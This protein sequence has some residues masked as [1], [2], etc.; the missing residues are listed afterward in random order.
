[1]KILYVSAMCGPRKIQDIHVRYR[2]NPGFAMQ[3]FNRLVAEGLVAAGAAVST[4]SAVPLQKGE[5]PTWCQFPSETCRGVRYRYIPFLNVEGIKQLMVLLYTFFY[6]LLW[7]M[8]GGK[9]KRVVCDVLNVS[10]CLGALLASK[11]NG[12]TTCGIITDLPGAGNYR[13]W[14]NMIGAKVNDL[15]VNS[16]DCYVLLTEAMNDKVNT[17]KR[18]YIVMEGL[19]DAT[20]KSADTL[21][22]Q[23]RTRS[24]V[25]AG[26]LYEKYGVKTLLDAFI[27]TGNQSFTLDLYGRGPMEDYIREQEAR[28]PRVRYHGLVDNEEIVKVERSAYLLVNPRHTNNEFTKYSFPSKN[29]EYMVSGTALL[30]TPLAGMPKDYYSHVY[31]FEDES[32]DGY[33]HTLRE[34]FSLPAE[35]VCERGRSGRDFVLATRNNK[36]QGS[37][38]IQ[39]LNRQS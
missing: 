7:G 34:L 18:P 28:H 37:R 10:V 32:V 27:K 15:Y 3:K 8:K 30:T 23:A 13:D 33:A 29:L 9:D 14:K 17:G 39:L 26:Q 35:K 4:L 12:L 25:Y 38:I 6:V 1:M 31:L 22:Q 2:R 36:I 16:F 11:L 19:V 5:S 20:E 24:V 21:A